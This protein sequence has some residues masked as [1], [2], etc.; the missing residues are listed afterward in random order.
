MQGYRCPH[1]GNPIFDEE[2][3]LCHFCG[4]SL[5][6]AG[7]GFLGKIRYSNHR[8]PGYFLT[9][10]VLCGLVFLFII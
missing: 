1:C 10:L 5:R 4:E 9:F 2:A 7:Q 3:L 6:R 8:I